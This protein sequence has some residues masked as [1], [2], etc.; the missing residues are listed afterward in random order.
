MDIAGY[1]AADADDL[2]KAI[3][4]KLAESVKKHKTRFVEGAVKNGI[5]ED[6]AQVI[7]KD[8]E[9][10]AN[11][12]FNKSHA[13]DYGL[14]AV[15]TAY[16]KTHYTVEFMTALLSASK[17]D[18]D[19]VA[20]YVADCRSMGIDILPPDV[21]SSCWD[22]SIEDRPGST[23]A[24][25]FGMGAVKNVG[26]APVNL[27][28]DAR[29]EGIFKDLNDFV[30]RVDLHQLGKRSLECLIRVGALDAFGPRRSLLDALD[31]MIS[32]S[33]SHFRALNSGQ[34]SFFGA[35][36]GVEEEIHL[37]P[38]LSLD[39]REQLEWEK[40]TAWNVR[41]RSSSRAICGRV[42]RQDHTFQQ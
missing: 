28:M 34:M 4:K 3:S 38:S 31:S 2:R 26:S 21:R 40:E 14:I 13:A 41:F 17:N 10:F 20:F 36:S 15:Q 29:R 19:K 12:G 39:S 7:F 18:T 5:D 35:I 11:Y 27:I 30:R 16:L 1:S 6:T 23:P 22:F 8:W 32:I 37:P 42:A 9:N 24:I 33:N 25:R